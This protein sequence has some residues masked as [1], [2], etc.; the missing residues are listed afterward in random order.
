MLYETDKRKAGVSNIVS[1][2]LQPDNINRLIT[3]MIKTNLIDNI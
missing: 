2:A 3:F 1:E